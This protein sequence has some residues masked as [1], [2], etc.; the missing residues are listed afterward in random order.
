MKVNLSEPF[1]LLKANV[2]TA[3]RTMSC[4][5]LRQTKFGSGLQLP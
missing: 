3:L 1:L 5:E 4:G 2:S